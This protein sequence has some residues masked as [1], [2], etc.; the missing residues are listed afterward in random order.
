[1]DIQLHSTVTLSVHKIYQSY[2][3]VHGT[4]FFDPS[5]TQNVHWNI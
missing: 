2:K 1:L 3:R 4:V 5:S